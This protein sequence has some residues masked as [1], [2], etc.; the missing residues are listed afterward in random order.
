MFDSSRLPVLEAVL[1][2]R[3]RQDELWGSQNHSDAWWNVIATEE[4]GEVAREIYERNEEKLF[5]EVIQTCA[6]YFQW[7]EAIHGRQLL[8]DQ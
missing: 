8:S 1:R 7:A 5:V 6:V 3:A 4:A 2:E